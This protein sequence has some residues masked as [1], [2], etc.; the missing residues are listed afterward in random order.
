[1]DD[2]GKH[3]AIGRPNYALLKSGLVNWE[4]IVTPNCVI[5]LDRVMYVKK[6]TVEQVVAVGVDRADAE[7]AWAI[8]ER[9]REAIPKFPGAG[10]SGELVARSLTDE[11]LKKISEERVLAA[12]GPVDAARVATTIVRDA[13]GRPSARFACP[14]DLKEK[15]R[16]YIERVQSG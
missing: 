4:D 10:V 5:R 3:R 15:L 11:Q 13:T 9:Q 12:L 1:M 16:E 6:L 14:D 8:L 7:H 2:A